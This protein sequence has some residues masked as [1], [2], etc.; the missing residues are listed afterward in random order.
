MVGFLSLITPAGL[1]VREATMTLTL[2]YYVPE[3]VGI[4][5]TLLARIWAT[6]VE[7]FLFLLFVKKLKGYTK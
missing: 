7:L 1:G 6:V 5:A 4:I 3:P 2:K